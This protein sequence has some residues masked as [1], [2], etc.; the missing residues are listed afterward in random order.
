MSLSKRRLDELNKEA[1][2]RGECHHGV[3]GECLDCEDEYYASDEPDYGGAFDGH[4]VYSDAD[5]GL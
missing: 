1:E 2:E 4:T 5:P 3:V